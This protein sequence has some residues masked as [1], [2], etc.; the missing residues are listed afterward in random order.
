MNNDQF[1][2]LVFIMKAAAKGKRITHRSINDKIAWAPSK[3]VTLLKELRAL[4]LI[5]YEDRKAATIRPRVQFIP[6]RK[7]P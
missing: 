7:L 5:S 2:L 3:I 4:G 6:E 1:K